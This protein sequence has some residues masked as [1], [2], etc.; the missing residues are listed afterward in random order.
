MADVVQIVPVAADQ[1]ETLARLLQLYLHDFS[2]FAPLESPYGE[3]GEDGSFAYPNLASY[4]SEPHREALLVRVRGRLAGFMLINDWSASGRPV[5]FAIAEFFIARKYRRCGIGTE[6]TGH[7]IGARP[8]Q[9]EVAVLADNTPAMAFWRR[10]LPA[11][12]SGAIEVMD[13]DGDR[14]RGSIFRFDTRTSAPLL[15]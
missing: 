8:G 5:D 11:V 4:L 12:H 14:W 2:A 15:D 7:V 6:T 13:G 9:W 1:A 10:A 3:I